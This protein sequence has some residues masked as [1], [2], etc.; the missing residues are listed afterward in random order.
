[1]KILYVTDATYVTAGRDYASEDRRVVA[2][3]CDHFTLETCRPHDVIEHMGAFDVTVLRNT[4][5]ILGYRDAY[6]AFRTHAEVT[7]TPV[8]NE[9][10]GQADQVG[11]QYL[12]DLS[13]AG[14]PVIPTI[15]DM[16][17]FDRLPDA[18]TFIIKPKFG[19][20]SIGLRRIPR[21]SLPR[22]LSDELVQPHLELESEVSIVYIDG[23]LS[24]AV[25]TKHPSRR[26]DLDRYEPTAQERAIAQRFV[27]WNSMAHG[28]QRVDLGRTTDG[29]VLLIELEDL[30]PYLSL[31]TLDATEHARFIDAFAAAIR[32]VVRTS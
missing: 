3:L 24:H 4:G 15:D 31:D 16:G 14:W 1:M 22:R 21:H 11:K 13:R 6:E 25:A 12:V 10:T 20:D 17:E 28:I 23:E 19:A 30:N 29:Q 18:G 27:D 26:W 2:A 8:Y 9:L 7:G 5:P 32:E